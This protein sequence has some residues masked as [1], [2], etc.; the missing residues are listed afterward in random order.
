MAR[1]GHIFY[2]NVHDTLPLDRRFT[3]KKAEFSLNRLR[4]RF[5]SVFFVRIG[6]NR[7]KQGMNNHAGE[8]V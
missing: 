3:I 2:F 8:E 5:K 1:R 6:C 7:C 4:S